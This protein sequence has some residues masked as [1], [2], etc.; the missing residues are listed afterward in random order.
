[1]RAPMLRVLRR[2]PSSGSS[3][4]SLARGTLP[5][6]MAYLMVVLVAAAAGAAVYLLTMRTGVAPVDDA[7]PQPT[8]QAPA[9]GGSYVPVVSAA[10][11][12]ESRVTSALGL[13]IA[14][15]VGA[16]ALAASTYMTFAFLARL[17]SHATG[18]S[19]SA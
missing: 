5:E 2:R 16:V 18:S 13:V 12:W 4:T 10:T 14:V 1:M 3:S 15:I 6:T 9:T 19:G 17:I 11:D 7:S 8:S